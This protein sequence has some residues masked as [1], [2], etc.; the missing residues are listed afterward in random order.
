MAQANY[1]LTLLRKELADLNFSLKMMAVTAARYNHPLDKH[2]KDATL[3][4]KLDYQ[5]MVDDLEHTIR[6][7][8]AQG[9]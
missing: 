2:K 4:S 8:E 6:F 1:S 3:K 5:Q 7:L 9:E